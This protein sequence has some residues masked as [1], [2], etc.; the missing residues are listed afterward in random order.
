MKILRFTLNGKQAFFKKPDVNTYYYFT[1]GHIHKVA[2]LGMFG[3]ILGYEGYN[4]CASQE[5]VKFPE[6]Y[7]KL[8]DIQISVVPRAEKGC[9]SRKI[10]SYNNSVGYASQ[11]KGGNLIVREQWLENPQ[12][13]IYVMLDCDEAKK[14]ADSV[15]RRTCI[16]TPYL[17]KN[18]HLADITEVKIINGELVPAE[19]VRQIDSLFAKELASVDV[20]DDVHENPYKYEESLP[21]ALDDRSMYCLKKLVLTNLPVIECA[22]EVYRITEDITDKAERINYHIIFQ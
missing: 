12:W 9:F 3:A 22:G 20:E 13:Y 19:Q 21:V 8:K 2:L 10:I 14:I 1:Y 16:Y 5:K 17:G 18:D 7:E 11:E 4:A 6:F 15:I